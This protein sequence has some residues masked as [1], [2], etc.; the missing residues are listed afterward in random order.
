MIITC[1]HVTVVVLRLKRGTRAIY[2]DDDVLD[3]VGHLLSLV[4]LVFQLMS[5]FRAVR[6]W[7]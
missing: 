4:G 5:L 7:I 3:G 2:T 6:K 1:C